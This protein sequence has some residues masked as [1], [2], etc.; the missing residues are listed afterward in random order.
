MSASFPRGTQWF[1]IGTILSLP[2]AQTK[3]VLFGVPLYAPEGF[4]LGALTCFLFGLATRQCVF[5]KPDRSLVRIAFFASLFFLGAAL[6]FLQNPMTTT[7]LGMLKSWFVFPLVYAFLFLQ[8]GVKGGRRALLRIWLVSIL[9]V[10]LGSLAFFLLGRVTYDGRLAFW[11]ASPN[12]LGIFLAP[13][14]LIALYLYRD[15]KHRWE[16]FL[17][18]LSGA[19]S[20]FVLYQTH[21][22]GAWGALGLSALGF[23]LFEA[24]EKGF[25]YRFAPL[26]LLMVIAGTFLLFEKHTAKWQ[27]LISFDERSSLASR[28]MIWRSAAKML[29]DDPVFGIG[30]GRFQEEYLAY[31]RSFPPYLEWAVP[32]PHNLYLAVWLQTG[33]VGLLGFFGLLASWLREQGKAWKSSSDEEK[34]FRIF[35]VS[36]L[37]LYLVYGLTDTPYFKNDLAYAFWTVLALGM[38]PTEKEKTA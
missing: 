31:Q 23:W 12:Y 20:L 33:V 14:V 1:L 17:L 6:S 18:L 26:V 21:S 25:R 5:R 22:Y 7:G 30:A 35:V 16:R 19:L 29:G 8:V 9:F 4:V 32:Q 2:F 38:L 10:A 3:A 37:G 34:A 11:Y 28:M 36:F 15:S 13:G 24:Q 27:D